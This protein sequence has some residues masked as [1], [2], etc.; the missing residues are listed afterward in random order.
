[1][2]PIPRPRFAMT[3][4]LLATAASGFCALGYET[5]WSRVLSLLTL[6]T[7]Y[8][9]S[10]MLA[11]LLLGLSL[12]S[13][14]IR[15]RLDRLREPAVWFVAIQLLLSFYALTSLLWATEIVEIVEGL[16]PSGGQSQ[17]GVWFGRP[18]VMAVMLLLVP[19]TLMGAAL[20]IAC[21]KRCSGA[22][23]AEDSATPS[24]VVAVV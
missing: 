24:V 17:F 23:S 6:N 18:F 15:G 19:T 7:T 14:L 21:T 13:W 20:P 1:M 10:L 9:F 11:V 4:V 16:L 22:L 3:L 8:A 5:I 12:G 2:T